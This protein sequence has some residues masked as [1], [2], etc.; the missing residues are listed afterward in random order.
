V[1]HYGSLG[2]QIKAHWKKYRPE[3]YRALKKAGALDEA[4]S[5][6]EELTADA[7][8]RLTVE[9]RLPYDQAWEMVRE[10]WAFLPES[11]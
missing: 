11:Y 8:Y 6:A 9:Q 4:V 3:M 10:E 2:L 5:Q 1:A 7:L